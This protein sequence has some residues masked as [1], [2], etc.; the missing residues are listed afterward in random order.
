[1]VNGKKITLQAGET[2]VIPKGVPHKPFNETAEVVI[3]NDVTNRYPSMTVSFAYGLTN[4]FSAMDKIGN[5]HSDR[6]SVV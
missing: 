5:P 1:M 4:I 6:K 3:F 2:I